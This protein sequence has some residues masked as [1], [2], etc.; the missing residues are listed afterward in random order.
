MA[1]DETRPLDDTPLLSDLSA[2]ER[3]Q[4]ERQRHHVKGSDVIWI[5]PGGQ[6]RR[7]P[8]DGVYYLQTDRGVFR[9]SR[10]THRV[11]EV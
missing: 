5:E 10:I 6:V 4:L 1:A 2:E 7:E 11:V 3:S 9:V 8:I